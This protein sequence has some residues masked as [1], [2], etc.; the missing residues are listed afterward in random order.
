MATMDGFRLLEIEDLLEASAKV[1]AGVWRPKG[2][3]R[4]DPIDTFTCI[5]LFKFSKGRIWRQSGC[6]ICHPIDGQG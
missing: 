6:D 1:E 3:Q 5:I 4:G 2:P